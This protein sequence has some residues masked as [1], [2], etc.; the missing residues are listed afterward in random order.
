MTVT[1]QQVFE[2]HPHA[3]VLTIDFFDTLVTRSVAQPTHVFAVMEKELCRRSG[4]RWNGFATQRVVS[5]HTARLNA[6]RTN[7]H[8]DVSFVEIMD[9]LSTV[10]GLD[11]QDRKMVTELEVET[12]VSLAVA[13]RFG[14][15]VAELAL[16]KGMDVVVVSDNYMSS[17]H[18]VNMAHAAGLAWVKNANVIVSSEHGAMKHNGSLWDV[19]LQELQ[20]DPGVILH[21]GDDAHADG[22]IPSRRGITTH[23]NDHMRRS[24]RHMM[25]TTPAVLPFSRLEAQ[26]RDRVSSGE[27]DAAQM[28]GALVGMIV[29]GQI[30]DVRN[31]MSRREVT[32]VHF[33]ARDGFIAHSV[34]ENLRKKGWDLPEASYFSFSRSVVWRAGIHV[35]DESTMAK[36]IGDDEELT[37]PRLERRL[38]CSLNS[39][40]DPAVTISA[41]TARQILLANSDN[42]LTASAEL[43]ERMLR[44]LQVQGLLDPGH[45]VVVDLGWTGSSIA[46][47]AQIVSEATNGQS[48]IEGRLTGLYWD[49]WSQRSRVSLHGFAMD[50]FHTIDD[51]RRLLGILNLLEVLVT[52]PH[53]SVVGYSDA[54]SGVVPVYVETQV[55]KDA[56]EQLVRKVSTIANRVALSILTD[57]EESSVTSSDITGQ[58]VWA[59]MMQMG[60][61]PRVEEIALSGLLRHVSAIDH[62]GNGSAL[63]GDAPARP[64]VVKDTFVHNVFNTLM[65]GHWLQGTLQDWRSE[66]A[67][68]AIVDDIERLFPFTHPQWV[69]V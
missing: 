60:H 41:V 7:A 51:N 8:R 56:F 65:H 44:Y 43:R 25:N 52:A 59:A 66:S 19:V 23:I 62:E 67:S 38:G 63:V 48:V 49:A 24:H 57:A 4:R 37:V 27:W 5:E 32:G 13:V 15:D 53:G 22:E 54:E 31:V 58:T 6:A 33:V 42:I 26:Y 2:L 64:K 50:D 35:V 68:A 12:E 47:L 28:F 30:V 14:A 36:F 3:T 11:D 46:D 61:S 69:N 40:I 55:E 45:H 39:T 34:W 18:I 16:S 17:E 21:V 1:A 20:V 10:M 9:E 29:A